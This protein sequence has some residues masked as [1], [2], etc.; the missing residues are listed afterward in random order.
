M[1]IDFAVVLAGGEGS[2]VKRRLSRQ[3]KI[4]LKIDNKPILQKNLE[5]IR[6]QLGIKSIIIVV[7]KGQTEI[8]NYFK[9]GKMLNLNL[10]Y[11]EAD[12][13]T[14]IADAL[15]L[16]KDK[17]SGTFLVMLGDE[18][19]LDSNHNSILKIDQSDFSAVISF[20]KTN[21][22]QDIANN[23]LIHF[24][25][26]NRVSELIEKPAHIDNNLLGVGTFVFKKN[27]FDY[28]KNI[29]I[30][31]K[32][33]RREL[34]DA[35][36]QLSKNEIVLAHELKGQYVNINTTDDWRLAKY[37]NNQKNFSKYKKSLVI[38]SYNEEESII[39]VINDFKNL[40]DEIIVVDGGSQDETIKKINELNEPLVKLIQGNFAGYGDAI[41]NG[42]EH[43]SGDIVILVEGDATFRSRDIHKMY[44]YIKDCDMVLGT[45]TTNELIHKG[46]NMSAGLRIANLMVA[47]FVEILWLKHNE[48]RFTDVGC[49]YRTFWKTEYDEIKHNFVGKGPEFSPEMMIEFIRNNK[50][51][52]EIPVSY[53]TRLGG[54]SK[55]SESKLAILKTGFKMLS[56]ILKKKLN[57]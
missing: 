23:Y 54:K 26:N 29:Q 8:Q 17:I 42:L 7:G 43:V 9:N 13:N 57:G 12:P 10:E 50:R 39:F 14:G 2:R 47:K 37:L 3:N 46:A 55:Y 5:I 22:L 19:Y 38:P 41:Q 36:S 34:I 20:M 16:V 44:E 4:L 11:V 6:D 1:K 24:S 25:N 27:I 56:L 21:N 45:R 52:I 28:L 35:I 33:K 30:N 51:V 18:F 48:P 40:V 32:T 53:Y 49:T 15:Y 31:K